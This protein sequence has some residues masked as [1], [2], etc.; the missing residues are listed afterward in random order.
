[1]GLLDS[2]SGDLLYAVRAVRRNPTFTVVVVM[3]LALG[4]GANT[5]VFSVLDSLLLKPLS[6]PRP[7]EL[8]ALRQIA[9]GATGSTSASDGLNLSPSMYLTYAENNRV[10]ESLGV[11]VSTNGTVTGVT[12]P[13]P[14]RAIGISNGVLETLKVPPAAGRWLLAEDQTGAVRPPPSV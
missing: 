12:E 4:I 6:Y 8:V 1:M 2:L 3:T 10:F 5:A 13:E 7:E 9:P 11:W 14:V